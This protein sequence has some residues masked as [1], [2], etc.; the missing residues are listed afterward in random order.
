MTGRPP[1]PPGTTADSHLHMRVSRRRKAAWVR[2]AA[3]QKL[4]EWVT[5]VLDA[6]SRYREPPAP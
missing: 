6:V 4:S 5:E 1:K 3:G 2:A